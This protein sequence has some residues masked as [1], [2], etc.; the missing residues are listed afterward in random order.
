M[1]R[2]A[3]A[4]KCSAEVAGN[5]Q[6]KVERQHRLLISFSV[7]PPSRS[8]PQRYIEMCVICPHNSATA[9]VL[10]ALSW[11]TCCGKVRL[12][13]LQD[14]LCMCVFRDCVTHRQVSLDDLLL[15]FNVPMLLYTISRLQSRWL[16]LHEVFDPRGIEN[17]FLEP[18]LDFYFLDGVGNKFSL[19]HEPRTTA[20]C[21]WKQSV[22]FLC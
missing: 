9:R 6:A 8:S 19:V 13:R 22:R 7:I 4:R 17:H 15:N 2:K 14:D 1:A 16:I 20:Q 21:R 10:Q 11:A 18:R 5:L 12:W 3:K